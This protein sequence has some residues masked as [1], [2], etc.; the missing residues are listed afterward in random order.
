MHFYGY[1]DIWMQMV[2]T[3]DIDITANFT[4]IPCYSDF[5]KAAGKHEYL[6]EYV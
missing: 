5:L 1:W 6:V 3:V 2:S 4:W